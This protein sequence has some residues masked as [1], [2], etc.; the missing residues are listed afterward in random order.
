M[1]HYREGH[2][3]ATGLLMLCRAAVCRLNLSTCQTCDYL[4]CSL[5]VCTA[6]DSSSPLLL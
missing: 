2:D 5:S 1:K 4:R 3:F 6:V